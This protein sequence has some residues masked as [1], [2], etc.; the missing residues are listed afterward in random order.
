M[1]GFIFSIVN[2]PIMMYYGIEKENVPSFVFLIFALNM[3][4]YQT[5]DA[6]D[7]KQARRIKASSPIGM[8]LDHGLDA[9]TFTIEFGLFGYAVNLQNKFVFLNCLCLSYIALFLALWEGMHSPVSRMN[10]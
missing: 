2:Y 3:F 5:F 10:L 8:L 9:L 4:I 6:V 1:I 7:G